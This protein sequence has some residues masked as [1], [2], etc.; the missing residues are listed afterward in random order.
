MSQKESSGEIQIFAS[1]ARL[2]KVKQ[3]AGEKMKKDAKKAKD[4]IGPRVKRMKKKYGKSTSSCLHSPSLLKSQDVVNLVVQAHGKSDLARACTDDE[5]PETVPEGW[6]CIHEKY[7]SKC[8]LRFPLPTLLLDLLD[9]YQLALSQLCPSV[10]RLV[11]GFITRAKEEGVIVGLSELMSLFLIKESSSKD[12]GGGTYYLPCRPGLEIEDPVKLSGKLTRAIHRMLQHSPNTWGAYTTS[13]VGSARFPERYKTSF[14][15]SVT[16]AGLEVSS[17]ASTSEKTQSQKMPIQPSFRSRGR[18]TKAA[19]SSRGSDKNQGGSFLSTVNDVLD[20][21]G[22]APAKDASYSE[23]KVQ[24]VVP[25]PEVP[26]VEADPQMA[27][28]THEFEPPR[29]KRSRTDQVDRPS[30]S[31]SCSSRGGTVGWNFTHSKPGSVFDDSWGLATL[32]RHMKRIGCALPSTANLTNKEEYVEI[33]HFM[34][35]LAGAIN[36]A[37]FKFEET[38]H[39]APNAGELAQVTELIRATKVEL[40]Q[41]RVQVSELQA[42]VKRLGSKADIQ[43]GK[44]ESQTVD[45]Q[46]KSRKIA[47]LESARKIAEYQVNELIAS[48]QDSQ[49]NIEAEVKL[50]VRRG[51]KEVAD[52]YNKI[53]A[54][55][56][57]KFAKKKDEVELHIY[58]QELQAN[59]DLLKDMMENEIQNA[60]DEY[61]RLMTLMPEAAAA[62]E[63]AQVSDFSISKLPLP[64][65][66]ESSGTFEINMFNLPFSGEY[67]SNLGLVDPDLAPIE[68]SEMG[69]DKEADEGGPAKEGEP[70]EGDKSVG[71]S[72]RDDDV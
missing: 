13:R 68:A 19:S 57:E 60:E 51:K 1:G 18:S 46:V 49:K 27:K 2:M 32:M 45:I 5:T 63:K 3:E 11:N 44:I 24:E 20:D 7:I 21:G 71:R 65:L 62:Y 28:D 37:Q 72:F 40:D 58:A 15:D 30:R 14:P 9:H 22:S 36:R 52:A 53:L 39:N 69:D 61:N 56:K 33:A 38:V 47:E 31:S 67:G 25:H 16:V 43:Q 66:S 48:S 41:A 64:Q 59:T 35:Q 29:S 4:L 8:H 6:F 42:E 50:V 12:G 34:G 17:G 10:I 70:S 26:E 23:P 55:V 54:S